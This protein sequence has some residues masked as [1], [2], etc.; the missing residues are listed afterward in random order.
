MSGARPPLPGAIGISHLKV[1]DSV[2]PDGLRGGTP[3]VHSICTEAYRVIGG[4]GSVQTISADGFQETPLEPG[5]LV[6]FT[7]GT[8]HR[9]VNPDGTLEILVLM[10]HD[11]L[12]EAG[13]MVL[14]LPDAVL[15]DPDRYW[16]RAVL[17]PASATTAADD[18]AARARR[19]LA[20]EGFVDLRAAVEVDD[21]APLERFYERAVALL[22]PKAKG[23]Q[24]FVESGV[25][26]VAGDARRR[27]D[28][29]LDGAT[30]ELA[31]ATLQSIEPPERVRRYG[32]CGT[33]GTYLTPG[34]RDAAASTA[35]G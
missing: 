23:W 2:A 9:L 28:A 29:V 10:D 27:L 11:G 4:H 3:H 14:T 32:C 30:D 8:I 21:R 24:T 25:D 1:Y 18:A 15:G 6:W 16:E 26:V 34:K 35:D 17:P 33:L 7:P 31:R 19:D 20:V 13:D 22:Q 5:S 12:P